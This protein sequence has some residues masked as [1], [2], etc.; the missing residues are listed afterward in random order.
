MGA[1]QRTHKYNYSLDGQLQSF[2]A[3]QAE[4]NA[5]IHDTEP[6]K[7]ILDQFLE[8]NATKNNFP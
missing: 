4:R 1:K 8:G 3:L 5:N 7:V 6:S 2:K